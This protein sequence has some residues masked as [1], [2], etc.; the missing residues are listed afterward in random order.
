MST[1]NAIVLANQKRSFQELNQSDCEEVKDNA[2]SFFLSRS[3]S[4]P[5]E[6]NM[7]LDIV[8]CHFDYVMTNVVVNK[9]TNNAETTFDLLN[10]GSFFL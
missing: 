7:T 10:S 2:C 3:W 8:L 6:I 4:R 1:C 5:P 9:S